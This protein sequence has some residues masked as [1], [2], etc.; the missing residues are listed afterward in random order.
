MRFGS[1]NHVL[2]HALKL[3]TCWKFFEGGRMHFLTIENVG[4]ATT[5]PTKWPSGSLQMGHWHKQQ[6]IFV[7]RQ[8]KICYSMVLWGLPSVPRE[9]LS[10]VIMS[11]HTHMSINTHWHWQTCVPA[12]VQ[13]WNIQHHRSGFIRWELMTAPWPHNDLEMN[14]CLCKSYNVPNIPSLTH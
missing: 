7:S 1:R 4:Y 6:L 2:P 13:C 9:T 5:H 8:Q 12:V 11:Q 10:T 3:T 14:V